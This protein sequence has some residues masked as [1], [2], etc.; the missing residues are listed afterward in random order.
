MDNDMLYHNLVQAIRQKIPKE[1][2]IAVALAEILDVEKDLVYRRLRKE[3]P[4]SMAETIKIAS[5]LEISIDHIVSVFFSRSN[6]SRFFSSEYLDPT[7]S[8]YTVLE[9]MVT[10][11]EMLEHENYSEGYDVSNTL[12]QPLF[13]RYEY[14]TRFAL[15]KWRK[16]YDDPEDTILYKDIKIPEK[17]RKLQLENIRVAQY[18]SKTNYILDVSLFQ[19]LTSEIRFFNSIGAITEEEVQLIKGDLKQVLGLLEK[20]TD[21]GCF[22][23]TGNDIDIY[24]SPVNFSDSY[25]IIETPSLQMALAKAFVVNAVAALDPITYT[26]MKRVIESIKRQSTLISQTAIRERFIYLEEQRKVIENM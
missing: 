8:Y 19:H 7:S 6:P 11:L 13:H 14:V 2:N 21:T 9:G 23:E 20:W 5:A 15:F 4:F 18:I 1:K 24:I 10:F 17:L 25:C 12:P 3:V 22:E 26:K 16:L